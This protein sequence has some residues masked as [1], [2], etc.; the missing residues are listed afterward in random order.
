MKNANIV[1]KIIVQCTFFLLVILFV[2]NSMAQ[3]TGAAINTTGTAA[4]NSAILDVSSSTQG[5]LV[6]RL[7]LTSTTSQSPIT[8][9]PANSLLVYNT[10]TTG[11]VT[12]GYYYWD[13]GSS[14][15]VRL[16]T[17]IGPT[18]PTGPAGNNGTAGS[19]GP[20]GPTGT[21]GITGPQGPAGTN[22]TNGSAG[23]TGPAGANGTNGTTGST[24]PTGPA[25]PTGSS[26]SCAAA[27]SGETL[28]QFNGCLYVKNA[29]ANGGGQT[30]WAN[31]VSACASLGAGWYLPDKME[32]DAIFQ[33]YSGYASAWQGTAGTLSGFQQSPY[34][35][36]TGSFSSQAYRI[37][38]W[39]G[40]A[41]YTSKSNNA[42]V[43][44]VRR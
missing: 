31:A 39:D 13:S 14:S 6:P 19:T 33:N 9:T 25:G 38:F 10:A 21:D 37:D 2:E 4:D 24:G 22:G 8:A 15:W 16:T 23:P 7:A 36:S 35:S 30:T 42:Y 26:A 32:L 41:S 29:D 18:G 34:W 17:G 1:R 20:T 44:C 12:P 27:G 43:R 3:T 40:A 28:I 5:M 11:D